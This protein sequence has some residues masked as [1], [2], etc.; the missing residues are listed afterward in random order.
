MAETTRRIDE[1]GKQCVEVSRQDLDAAFPN[2][3]QKTNLYTNQ[4]SIDE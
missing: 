2:L 1:N 3:K 4:G